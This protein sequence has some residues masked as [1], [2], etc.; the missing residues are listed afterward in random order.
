MILI[1]ACCQVAQ[2][3]FII[4]Y[5]FPEITRFCFNRI[6]ARAGFPRLPIQARHLPLSAFLFSIS[7]AVQ[8]TPLGNMVQGCY[9]TSASG[10]SDIPQADRVFGPYQRMHCIILKSVISR[11]CTVIKKFQLL[12]LFSLLSYN[13]HFNLSLYCIVI[14]ITEVFSSRCFY[15]GFFFS[16][17]SAVIF[18]NSL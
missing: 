13:N 16:L 3:C 15:T 2:A 7:A 8:T 9:N 18:P 17:F 10:L 11:L 6:R 1:P 14:I 5:K 4:F 12:R